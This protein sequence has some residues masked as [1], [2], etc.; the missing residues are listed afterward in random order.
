MRETP[1]PCVLV[2]LSGCL[3]VLTPSADYSDF[4]IIC[5]VGFGKRVRRTLDGLYADL[6]SE[7]SRA[8]GRACEG[9]GR[10][11][12]ARIAEH[13]HAAHQ[14]ESW[15]FRILTPRLGEADGVRVGGLKDLNDGTVSE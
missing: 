5:I 13:M 3:F 10:Q 15:M 8:R 6:T 12:S 1:L 4:W 2:C 14:V 11:H 7:V 9:P